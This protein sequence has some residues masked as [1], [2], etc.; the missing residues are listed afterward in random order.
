MAELDIKWTN[1][2]RVLNEFADEVISQARHNLDSNNSNASHQLYDTM[3]K[4]VEIGDERM[5]VSVSLE[6]YWYYLE[7]G[8]GPGKYPPPEAIRNWI[9]VKPI[10]ATPDINGRTPSVDQLTFLISR[11]IAREGTQPHPFLQPAVDL[12]LPKYE[13]LI[14]EAMEEDISEFIVELVEKGMKDALS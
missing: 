2:L 10:S 14:S 5:S 1:L 4:V 7:N 12:V 9:E 6:D 11:K 13:A 8:R 3:E